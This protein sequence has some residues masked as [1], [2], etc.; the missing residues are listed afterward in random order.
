MVGA[1]QMDA[2]EV[3]GIRH[4]APRRNEK[5]LLIEVVVE[6]ASGTLIGS[7]LVESSRVVAKD[8]SVTWVPR[9]VVI[10][11]SELESAQRKVRTEKHVAAMEFATATFEEERKRALEKEYQAVERAPADRRAAAER[12][13]QYALSRYGRSP[14]EYFSKLHKTVMPPLVSLRVLSEVGPPDMPEVR[15]AA[16]RDRLESVMEGLGNHIANA[17]AQGQRGASPSDSDGPRP[18]RT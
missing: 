9:Q 18:K 15:E 13:L 6:P 11:A 4:I 1:V 5:R 8:G 16:S 14:Q 3:Q 10:Y 7:Q 12:S 2:G 17:I